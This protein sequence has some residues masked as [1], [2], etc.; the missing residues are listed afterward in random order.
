MSVN[1]SSED[2]DLLDAGQSVLQSNC[3]DIDT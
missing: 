1:G 3:S 2:L